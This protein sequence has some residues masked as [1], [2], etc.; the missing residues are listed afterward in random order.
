M[1]QVIPEVGWFLAFG[2]GI[3]SFLSPCVAPLVPGYLSYVSG[4]SAHESGQASRDQTWRVASACLLFV[5]G[6]SAVF[7]LLGASAGLLGGFLDEYRR[8]LNR[9]AGIVMILM[10]LFILGFF[11]LPWLYRD[12]R[13]HPAGRPFGPGGTVLLGAAF[14]VGWTPCI[15]PVLASILFYAGTA[16]TAGRGALLLLA[17]SLG[18][19]LPFIAAGVGFARL[20]GAI[21]WFKKHYLLVNRVGGG[22]LVAVGLLFL[23]DRFFYLSIA[24]Q[25]LYYT[26]AR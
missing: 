20:A 21:G 16:E 19:G 23:S 26:L 1:N 17:Y 8:P 11:R 22:L 15:G 7:V 12:F 18:L 24:A 2:A 3:L 25:R 6:F 10:G 14:G 4:Y 9:L 13:F 5:T